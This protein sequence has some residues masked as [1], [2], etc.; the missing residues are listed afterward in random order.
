[1]NIACFNRQSTMTRI[2]SKLEEEGSFLIKSIEIKFHR[3]S[4]I[5]SC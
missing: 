1:M 4:G 3:C 2:M 5:G